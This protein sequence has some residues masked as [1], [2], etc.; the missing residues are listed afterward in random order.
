MRQGL[1]LV[2]SV[3]LLVQNTY[4][5]ITS[6][7]P[8]SQ[9]AGSG[10][11]GILGKAAGKIIQVIT[12]YLSKVLGKVGVLSSL[13]GSNGGAITNAMQNIASGN[14][15]SI[16]GVF[17]TLAPLLGNIQG[18]QVASQL[19]PGLSDFSYDKADFAQT[20]NVLGG[21]YGGPFS[22]MLLEADK[23]DLDKVYDFFNGSSSDLSSVSQEL[24]DSGAELNSSN[25]ASGSSQSSAE[26]SK[27]VFEKAWSKV[28]NKITVANAIKFASDHFISDDLGP[29]IQSANSGNSAN[30]NSLLTQKITQK[31]AQQNAL[32]AKLTTLAVEKINLEGNLSQAEASGD[33]V[34][35][36]SAKDSLN[37][38]NTEIDVTNMSISDLA[39]QGVKLYKLSSASSGPGGLNAAKDFATQLLSSSVSNGQIIEKGKDVLTSIMNSIGSIDFD[40]SFSQGTG[41]LDLIALGEKIGKATIH[42]VDKLVDV[43]GDVGSGI[44]NAISAFASGGLGSGQLS[45]SDFT[46]IFNAKGN[47]LGGIDLSS[48]LSN[49]ANSQ[50]VA[51]PLQSQLTGLLGPYKQVFGQ[52]L[53]ALGIK[54]A[55]DNA[56]GGLAS[57][58]F[59]NGNGQN[60]SDGFA[61]S[62]FAGSDFMSNIPGLGDMSEIFGDL[63]DYFNK[64][65]SGFP[66][67]AATTLSLKKTKGIKCNGLKGKAKKVCKGGNLQLK[68][69][70]ADPEKFAEEQSRSL[71]PY[72]RSFSERLADAQNLYDELISLYGHYAG[73]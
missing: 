52:L 42:G 59:G 54:S 62:L 3:L 10:I 61:G 58:L 64:N 5:Q 47:S 45:L 21:Q 57:D 26:Q 2:I 51:G 44:G 71:D 31:A 28:E 53:D 73:I 22:K 1:C 66:S 11:A 69:A 29:L 68:K 6:Y 15:S 9:A 32:T 25:G 70:K 43:I 16:T 24:K 49:L 17:S 72:G 12:P 23:D 67:F 48:A 63:S 30:F 65:G 18:F 7:T 34:A 55:L 60:L 20:V 13:V 56:L 19:L 8:T 38:K 36:K 37:A 50:A 35:I 41:G 14:L 27:S 40:S 39:K 33:P 4:G 46:N